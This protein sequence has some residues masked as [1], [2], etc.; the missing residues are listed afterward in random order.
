M[1]KPWQSDLGSGAI[2]LLQ[3]ALI[4]PLGGLFARPSQALETA[5]ASIAA[6]NA[7]PVA[8]ARQEP[9][10]FLEQLMLD[11]P[12]Y[13]NRVIQRASQ[14]G[15][16]APLY[17]I[18]AGQAEICELSRATFSENPRRS[19]LPSDPPST[20]QDEVLYQIFFT[21]LERQY[22]PTHERSSNRPPNLNLDLNLE[23][24]LGAAAPALQQ[25]HWLILA[26]AT[27][28]AQSPWR[29]LSLRSQLASYPAQDQLRS[30]T[31]NANHSPIA[32]GIELWLRD[33][34]SRLE[35][36]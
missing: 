9:L 22:R 25:F 1:D 28:P 21:T 32:E 13:S 5:C 33:Y 2:A 3:I 31:R 18:L 11:L 35:I 36:P 15:D 19:R 20:A 4:L 30:P 12:S 16:A 8:T 7:T 17:L 24:Q 34:Q 29:L 14:M 23:Q 6:P 26:R 27:E 10:A